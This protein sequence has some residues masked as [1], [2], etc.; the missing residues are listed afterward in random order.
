MLASHTLG[1]HVINRIGRVSRRG[2]TDLVRAAYAQCPLASLL[3][4]SAAELVV[5]FAT[6]L[7][8]RRGEVSIT[9]RYTNTTIP[10]GRRPN[11]V[12]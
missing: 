11:Y 7:S 2:E 5:M 4:P 12:P 9:Y 6:Q 8:T 3:P 1:L 10:E